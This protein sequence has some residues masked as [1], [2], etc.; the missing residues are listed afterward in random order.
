[1]N[2]QAHGRAKASSLLGVQWRFLVDDLPPGHRAP[3]APAPPPAATAAHT[4]S[5]RPL[6]PPGMPEELV[7]LMQR[8][9]QARGA[10]PLGGTKARAAEDPT[11]DELVD[12]IIREVQP[13]WREGVWGSCCFPPP[14]PFRLVACGMK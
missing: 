7:D 2:A 11:T 14:P 10:E 1:M 3:V 12:A 9:R 5:T 4:G 6:P 8:S 13:A